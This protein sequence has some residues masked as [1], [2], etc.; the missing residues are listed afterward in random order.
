MTKQIIAARC[1]WRCR[2]RCRVGQEG[3]ERI[4]YRYLLNTNSV[5][6]YCLGINFVVEIEFFVPNC[7]CNQVLNVKGRQSYGSWCMCKAKCPRCGGF[8]YV[9]TLSDY[10]EN[11]NAEDFKQA[12]WKMGSAWETDPGV[13][14]L[15]KNAFRV[16][17]RALRARFWMKIDE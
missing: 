10:L 8:G 4:V 12:Q 5:K 7:F 3:R 9:S 6:I 11:R 13:S 1:Q 14:E 2:Y 16:L 15:K 17:K